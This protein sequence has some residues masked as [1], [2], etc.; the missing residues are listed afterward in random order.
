MRKGGLWERVEREVLEAED[1]QDT[2][3]ELG[4]S[5]CDVVIDDIDAPEVKLKLGWPVDV[6]NDMLERWW[7]ECVGER[8]CI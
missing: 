8:A 5:D 2:D 4:V 6:T 3:A 7:W 1:V